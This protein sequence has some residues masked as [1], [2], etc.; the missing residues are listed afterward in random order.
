MKQYLLLT[1]FLLFVFNDV[2][3]QN[4]GVG[5]S[6]PATKFEI[7]GN[8]GIDLLNVK[9]QSNDSKLY[10]QE[11]GNVGIG[12]TSPRG[13][14]HIAGDLVT[15]NSAGTVRKYSSSIS[16]TQ[17]GLFKMGELI[18]GGSSNNVLVTGKVYG[19]SGAG[20]GESD[21][22]IMVRTNTFPGKNIKFWQKQS[23][24]GK[25]IDL[26][27]YEDPA[28]GRIVVGFEPSS[29]LQSFAWDI[30][31]FERGNYNYWINENSYTELDPAGLT[32]IFPSSEDIGW[33]HGGNTGIGTISPTQK[34]D[35]DGNVRVRGLGAGVL[36][37]DGS[38]NI[39]SGNIDWSNISNVPGEKWNGTD[40]TTG[41]INRTGNVS[42]GTSASSRKL[43]VH[44]NSDII[45]NFKRTNSNSVG[46]SFE[47]DNGDLTR[48]YGA[49][50]AMRVFHTP[51]GGSSSEVFTIE[52]NGNVGIGGATSPSRNLEVQTEILIN[53]P[54]NRGNALLE[55]NRGGDGKDRAMVVHSNASTI[56]WYS[57][58]PYNCGSLTDQYVISSQGHIS[59]CSVTHTPEFLIDAD[60]DV[61][62]GVT[63]PSYKLHVN[64]RLKTNGINETSDARLKKNVKSLDKSLEKVLALRGVNY[65][66]RTDEFSEMEFTEGIELGLIAQEV[67]KI[68]PELVDT[69]NE[70]YKSVQY[71]HVVPLLIEAIKEQQLIINEKDQKI[72]TIEALN[73]E[74]EER[75]KKLENAV[76][77]NTRESNKISVHL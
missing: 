48:I 51:N 58:I 30:T 64:G 76:F 9:D 77:S 49:Q 24:A 43:E 66:W 27:V 70:G 15:S 16:S 17:S 50:K 72:E 39:S 21:F 42:I 63:N 73:M 20:A 74:Q 60:G 13:K 10:V 32:E 12:T 19:Q 5:E 62:I 29:G 7:K 36:S 35:V 40:N 23:N 55:L 53:N 25:I 28:S 69:D 65:E 75:I 1:V 14:M 26:K 4:V 6:T 18:M 3:S 2:I 67:E 34:L 57:G 47:G 38:G 8:A 31:I 44:D 68:L 46:I 54:N 61:G 33:T 56:D 22:S 71:S 41:N 37:A 52:A 11:D 59:D 45:A